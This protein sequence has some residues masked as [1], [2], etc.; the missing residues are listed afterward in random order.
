MLY[1]ARQSIISMGKKMARIRLIYISTDGHISQKL[2]QYFEKEYIGMDVVVTP[3]TKIS[4]V[5]LESNTNPFS[6]NSFVVVDPR[7]WIMM[8]YQ[9][10]NTEQQTLYTL[11]KNIVSDMKR[12]IK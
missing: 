2:Q 10:E 3:Q 11:S 5:F 4:H 7:G 12:L 8:Q 9:L 6:S 1:T